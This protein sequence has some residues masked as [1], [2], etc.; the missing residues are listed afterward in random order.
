MYLFC[1]QFKCLSVEGVSVKSKKPDV[2]NIL[3]NCLSI[4]LQ[5]CYGFKSNK[6]IDEFK[7]KKNTSGIKLCNLMNRAR[8]LFEL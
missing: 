3:P 6:Y 4:N 5:S 8:T 1:I 2:T 7:V